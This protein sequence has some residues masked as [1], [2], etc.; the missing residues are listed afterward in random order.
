VE[1]GEAL[2]ACGR[3]PSEDLNISEGYLPAPTVPRAR[4]AIVFYAAW[5]EA[6]VPNEESLSKGVPPSPDRCR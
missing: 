5:P 4:R 2:E 3:S 1:Q 6:G